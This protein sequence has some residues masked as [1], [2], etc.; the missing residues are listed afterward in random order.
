[1]FKNTYAFHNQ[2]G[3]PEVIGFQEEEITGVES[4]QVLVKNGAAG[5]N[6]VDVYNR[7]GLYP[8]ELP[9]RMGF[10]GAGEVVLVGDEVKDVKVGDTVAYRTT[11]KGA[12]ADFRVAARNEIVH[13]PLGID[14]LTAAG[15]MLKGLTAE[16]LLHRTYQV[17]SGETIL[18]HA[19]AGG[20]GL[21][22]CQWAK[23]LG[24]TVIGTAGSDEKVKLALAN[25]CTHAINY[26]K[27]NF[28][29][30]VL[31]LTEGK[32]VPVVYDSVG[33]DTFNDSLDCLSEFGMMVSYGNASGAVPPIPLTVLK[34]HL[35]LARP[36]LF[37]FLANSVRY[38]EM[39]DNLFNVVLAKKVIP[40][41]NHRY[42]LMDVAQAHR[43]L[44]ARKTTGSI[45]ITFS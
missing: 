40:H 32:G 16:Y 43:D 22:L 26:Q 14:S 24:V 39:A 35:F 18:V 23:A 12:Y 27:Q 29:E 30:E 34:G 42:P 37:P 41:I 2:I 7:N 3:G 45:V 8:T 21:I 10:E 4:S 1:M 5:V 33:K 9:A 25:G 19:A 31:R 38:Q 17:K 13:L 11:D 44:E 15:I 36:S 28:K 20:V 6:F